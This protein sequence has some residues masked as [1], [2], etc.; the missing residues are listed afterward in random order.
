MQDMSRHEQAA[1]ALRA[2]LAHL[3]SLV[4]VGGQAVPKLAGVAL[5]IGTVSAEL[6]AARLAVCRACPGGHYHNGVCGKLAVRTGSTCGCIVERKAW[7]Q[8]E[9][10]PNNYWN[11]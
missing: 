9:Q 8:S 3:A 10:C 1:N 7:L 4:S 2:T 5:G 6:H 11:K